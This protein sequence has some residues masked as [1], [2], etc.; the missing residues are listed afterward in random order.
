MFGISFHKV[1]YTSSVYQKKTRYK[2]LNL[3]LTSVHCIHRNQIQAIIELWSINYSLSCE[4]FGLL[5]K[6]ARIV[7]FETF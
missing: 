1:K 7:H 3:P 4:Y 5:K 2:N 6:I